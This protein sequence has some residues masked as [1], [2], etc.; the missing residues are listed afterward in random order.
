M[1]KSSGPFSVLILLDL[2]VPF[3]QIRHSLLLVTHNL[4]GFPR[5]RLLRCSC[6]LTSY[7]FSLFGCSFSLFLYLNMKWSQGSGLELLFFY[8][9][10]LGQ[11]LLWTEL[12]SYQNAYAEVL[13]PT[14]LMVFGDG[15][16]GDVIWIEWGH[17]GRPWFNGIGILIRGG[18]S[19]QVTLCA[20]V[21]KKAM[22][23]HREKVDSYKPRREA[24]PE[25]HHS[26]SP[27]DPGFL[28][29]RTVRKWV[30]AV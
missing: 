1:V 10:S 9:H 13:S 3:F 25:T 18:R 15:A 21:E 8:T 27:T 29:F 5:P 28:A 6:S 26:S 2:S 17:M 11:W 16:T 30:Y 7:P 14:V 12:Y 4:L 22:W 19:V 23:A 24:S 20:S